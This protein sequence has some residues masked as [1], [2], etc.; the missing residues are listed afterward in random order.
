MTSDGRSIPLELLVPRKAQ[1]ADAPLSIS[2]YTVR[3]EHLRH[4]EAASVRI[5]SFGVTSYDVGTLRSATAPSTKHQAC[6]L[7]APQASIIII[8]V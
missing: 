8:L 2:D 7:L 4:M 3:T 6:E 5:V 1:P